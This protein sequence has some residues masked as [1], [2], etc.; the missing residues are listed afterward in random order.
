[1]DLLEEVRLPAV[2]IGGEALI[3]CFV[4]NPLD[5]LSLGL[6]M[7]NGLVLCRA[8]LL[9]LVTSQCFPELGRMAPPVVEE[10]RV[11]YRTSVLL[12]ATDSPA[13]YFRFPF[14]AGDGQDIP[15]ML[16]ATPA[17]V[18]VTRTL[19]CDIF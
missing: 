5:G 7:C 10:H 17:T 12:A 1:M 18:A 16:A 9:L 8:R 13:W 2:G 14:W 19:G 6:L 4:D 11:G 15:R 3:L